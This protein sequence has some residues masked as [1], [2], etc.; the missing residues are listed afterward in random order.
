MGVTV[1]VSVDNIIIQNAGVCS[2]VV[3]FLYMILHVSFA[4]GM[5]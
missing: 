1:I 3:I 2:T 4:E 5:M